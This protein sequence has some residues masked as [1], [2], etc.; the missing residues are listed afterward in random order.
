MDTLVES[1]SQLRAEAKER[2]SDEEFRRAEEGFD[3]IVA[4]VRASRK[5]ALAAASLKG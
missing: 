1:F 4:R 3:R 5:R 2:M